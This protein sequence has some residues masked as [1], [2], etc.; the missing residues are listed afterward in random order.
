MV[1]YSAQRPAPRAPRFSEVMGSPPKKPPTPYG[2]PAYTETDPAKNDL[3]DAK[4]KIRDMAHSMP[5]KRDEV[6]AQTGKRT[7]PNNAI[8]NTPKDQQLSKDTAGS[9]KVP[10]WKRQVGLRP[11]LPSLSS[12]MSGD[13][14]DIAFGSLPL[15]DEMKPICDMRKRR[16]CVHKPKDELDESPMFICL[17]CKNRPICEACLRDVLA[18]PKDPHQADHYLYHWKP[19]S[20]LQFDKFLWERR[21]GARLQFGPKEMLGREWLYSD[22]SFAPSSTGNL[23]VRFVLNAHPGTYYVSVG[24]HTYVNPATINK[25]NLG[26]SNYSMIKAG[27]TWIGSLAVGMQ[28]IDRGAVSAGRGVNPCFQRLPDKIVEQEVRKGTQ[29]EETIVASGTVKVLE[30]QAVEVSIRHWHDKGIFKRG[31]PFKWWL[32]SITLT[33]VVEKEQIASEADLKL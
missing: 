27:V 2:P 31:S 18:N 30:G 26:K 1:T 21:H 24:V 9:S 29:N 11:R 14:L 3:E 25:D 4:K 20:S 17:D 23:T 5:T 12:N 8:T 22:H 7:A 10:E 16:K 19:T 13:D 33:P 6:L 15:R 32:D 28:T